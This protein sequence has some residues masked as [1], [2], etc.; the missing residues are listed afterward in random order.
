MAGMKNTKGV[1]STKG[2]RSKKN[3]KKIE[4]KIAR[5]KNSFTQS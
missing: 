4:K 1:I 2:K 3:R 5:K